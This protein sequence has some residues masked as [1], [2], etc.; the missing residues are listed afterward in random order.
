MTNQTNKKRTFKAKGI[1]RQ[2]AIL[3]S[4]HE[5]FKQKGYYAT[6]V[7]QISRHCNMAMGTFYQYFK[8]KEEI[9]VALNDHITS[10]FNE[11]SKKIV[12]TSGPFDKRFRSVIALLFSH[13]SSNFSFHSTLGES[14]LVDRVTTDYYETLITFFV[15]Y[16]NKEMEYGH[17]KPIDPYLVSYALLGICYFN[18]MSWAHE[19]GKQ[20][21][22]K[23]IDFIVDLALNGINGPKPWEKP[24]G[25][26]LL[27]L[28]PPAPLPLGTKKEM[29]KG[30]IT[31]RSIFKAAGRVFAKHGV[32]K[33][34]IS[35]ITREAGVAQ[36]TFYIHFK[37]KRE[38][39]E[40]YVRYISGELRKENQKYAKT[41]LD[42]RDV[43]RVGMVSFFN[44][45]AEHREIYRV[46]PEYEMV[47]EKVG[48]WF[49]KKMAQGYMAGLKDGIKE[50]E[51]RDLPLHMLAAS[52]MGI[53]HFIGLKWLVWST[54]PNAKIDIDLFEQ[55]IEFTF[56][57]LSS[58]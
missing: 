52:L 25:K 5:V 48:Y 4:A 29:T 26:N 31:R 45:C 20:G 41:M 35:D 6:S 27:H 23:I 53:S 55:I 33:A 54:D 19:N 10:K 43:E 50:N 44:F 14:E 37:S 12:I 58:K 18:S 42:R 13:I 24:S 11:K 51:I 38:L 40:G 36:G 2:K 3:E 32:N 21:K 15:R 22:K 28:P 17:I 39:V 1:A 9:F 46:V 7:S 34:S 8:N 47:G 16:F 49:Y 30:D 56:Y 57:G